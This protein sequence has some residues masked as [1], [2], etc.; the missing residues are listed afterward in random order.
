MESINKLSKKIKEESYKLNLLKIRLQ[1]DNDYRDRLLEQIQ[2]N[3]KDI[4]QSLEAY[5][6][7]LNIIRL[8][9][10]EVEKIMSDTIKEVLNNN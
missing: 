5:N 8:L 7:Q 2:K 6:Q 10:N 3:D 9:T 1:S 4:K